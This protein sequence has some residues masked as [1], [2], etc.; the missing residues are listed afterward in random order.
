M[1]RGEVAADHDDAGRVDAAQGGERVVAFLE[2]EGERGAV[3]ERFFLRQ[4][5]AQ[6]AAAGVVG[7]GHV[8]DAD[9]FGGF[10]LG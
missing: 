7:V 8:E 6:P 9:W 2:A 4:G 3:A 10:A 1:A 5:A